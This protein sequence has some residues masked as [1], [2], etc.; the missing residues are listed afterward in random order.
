MRAG[1]VQILCVGYLVRNFVFCYDWAEFECQN[2]FPYQDKSRI[3]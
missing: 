1:F 2:T 3:E